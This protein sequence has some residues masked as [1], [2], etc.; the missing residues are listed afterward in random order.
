ML[1][2]TNK[3][4]IHSYDVNDVLTV[5]RYTFANS[6]E[7]AIDKSK[8]DIAN[9]YS[10]NTR[11]V[12]VLIESNV[13]NG[14][15]VTNEF[16]KPKSWIFNKEINRWLP[17]TPFPNDGNRYRWDESIINWVKEDIV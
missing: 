16:E 17:P 15:L 7:E 8:L 14:N 5:H 9:L 2:L 10:N 4:E 12:A 6:K 13:P 11:H 1:E 3:Y